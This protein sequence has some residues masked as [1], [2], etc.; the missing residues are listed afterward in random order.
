MYQLVTI[1]RRFAIIAMILI[2][3]IKY[4]VYI[5]MACHYVILLSF[6]KSETLKVC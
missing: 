6:Y 1:L 3:S 4:G 2:S 5:V